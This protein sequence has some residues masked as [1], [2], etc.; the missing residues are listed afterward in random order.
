MEVPTE[1]RV[2]HRSPAAVDTAA[3]FVVA[4]ALTNVA[5][6]GAGA[7]A[8]ATVEQSG[9]RLVI[10]VAD[11]GPGGADPAGGALSGLRERVQAL[12]GELTVTSPEGEGTTIRAELPC[13]S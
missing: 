13:E 3:T 8:T 4:E 7:A 12:A 6:H 1:V 10:V 9:D 2:L 5:K 11:D